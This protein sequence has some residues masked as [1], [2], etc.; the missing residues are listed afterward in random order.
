M[1]KL[2]AE[3][4]AGAAVMSDWVYRWDSRPPRECGE[5]VKKMDSGPTEVAVFFIG[6]SLMVCFRGTR[7]I[8]DWFYDFRLLAK[9]VRS[10]FWKEPL[11][12]HGGFYSSGKDLWPDLFKMIVR[13][14]PKKV[15]SCGHSKGGGE[16]TWFDAAIGRMIESAKINVRAEAVTFGAPRVWFGRPQS[17]VLRVVNAEDPAPEVPKSMCHPGGHLLFFCEDGA[18]V[19]DPS[20]ERMMKEQGVLSLRVGSHGAGLYSRRTVSWANS[21]GQEYLE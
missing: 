9:R 6:D 2:T 11:V 8:R 4:L 21:S 16:A 14:R 20:E 5:L 7:G 12:G 13:E 1:L 15:V 3:E 19:V 10:P 17:S 18:G